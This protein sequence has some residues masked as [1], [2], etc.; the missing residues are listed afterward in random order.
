MKTKSVV[1]FALVFFVGALSEV[2]SAGA[3]ESME[4]N[5]VVEE[6]TVT[7]VRPS[8]PSMPAGRVSGGS[9]GGSRGYSPGQSEGQDAKAAAERKRECKKQKN[10]DIDATKDSCLADAHTYRGGEYTRCPVEE[11]IETELNTGIGRVNV[12]TSPRK[13]CTD[14]VDAVY[15]AKVSRCNSDASNSKSKVDA[16]CR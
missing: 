9:L 1:S 15:E 16:A 6:V 7:G 10:L 2:T 12:K 4:K 11:S 8:G 14:N 3:P 5:A 13:N